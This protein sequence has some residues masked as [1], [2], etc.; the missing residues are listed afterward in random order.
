MVGLSHLKVP[1]LHDDDSALWVHA[2]GEW[3]P[4]RRAPARPAGSRAPW[5]DVRESRLGEAIL[6]GALDDS[7]YDFRFARAAQQAGLID[8]VHDE[9][10]SLRHGNHRTGA[11]TAGPEL[12]WR[13]RPR[14]L[15]GR[16]A[17]VESR[18]A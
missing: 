16:C 17:Q 1:D 4:T 9:L 7:G 8:H 18:P 11:W 2:D 3:L 13:A 14:A 15:R 12:H 10:W 6:F 5:W